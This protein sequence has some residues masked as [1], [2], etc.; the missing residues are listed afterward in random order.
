MIGNNS[1]WIDTL[2][3]IIISFGFILFSYILGLMVINVE[4]PNKHRKAFFNIVVGVI[5]FVDIYSCIMT[6]FKTVNLCSLCL[7]IYLSIKGGGK[8]NYKAIS[9]KELIP[10]LYIISIVFFFYNIYIFSENIHHDIKYYSRIAYNLGKNGEENFYHFYNDVDKKYNGMIPYHYI[11][12]WLASLFNKLTGTLAI[13]SLKNFSYPFLISLFSYGILSVVNQNKLTIFIMFFSISIFPLGNLIGCYYSGWTIFTDFWI[14]PNLIMYY[15]FYTMV[16][17]TLIDNNWQLFYV[18]AGIGLTF[19]VLIIP[20]IIISL[21]FLEIIKIF[22]RGTQYRKSIELLLIPFL[23][24]SLI[25]VLYYFFN[26]KINIST[27]FSLS[28]SLI[29]D[30]KIWKAVVS[31][32]A[33]I[34]IELMSAVVI[35]AIFN[36]YVFKKKYFQLYLL[37]LTFI[38]VCGLLIFQFLNKIDNAY[39]FAYLGY[40]GVGFALFITVCLIGDSNNYKIKLIYAVIP[41]LMIYFNLNRFDFIGTR[42][43]IRDSS[44]KYENVSK[45]WVEQYNQNIIIPK[46]TKG[47]FVNSKEELSNINPKLRHSLSRQLG[48]YI[49][50]LT[51]ESDLFSITCKDTLLFDYENNNKED[52]DKALIWL[53]TF[54]EYENECDPEKYLLNKKIDYF[55]CNSN[56]KILDSSFK[57][58]SDKTMDTKLVY[59]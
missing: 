44:L 10:F 51:D 47:S 46:K 39:Q 56:R 2:L 52:F 42:E 5:L 17:C 1:Y 48:S 26:S 53:N 13:F 3:L 59:R 18:F 49:C 41:I 34:F 25:V 43:S 15:L 57:I 11:E 14:R 16:L 19:S 45:E 33:I 8:F 58:L 55:I 9:L 23:S 35:F 20:E 37:F 28:D 38:I 30:I 50:F 29:Y 7:I 6:G 21:I 22:N 27:K 54:S 40:S 12:F 31:T 36:K 24:L 4:S 32:F